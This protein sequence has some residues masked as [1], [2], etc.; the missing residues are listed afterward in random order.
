REGFPADPLLIADLDRLELRFLERQAAR[1]DMDPRLPEGVRRARSASHEQ[2]L[3][4]MLERPAGDAEALFELA[5]LRAAFLGTCHVESAEMAA[6]SIWQRVAA[7]ELNAELRGIAQERFAAIVAEEVDLTLQQKIHLLRETGAVMGA[8][9]A[10]SDE[11]LFRRLATRLEHAAGDRSLYQRMESLLSRGGV[12]ALET[13][14]LFLLVVVFV[15]LGIEA[16]V[17]GLSESTLRWMRIADATICT[18]FVLEFLFKFTL[19]PR[20]ASWFVRNFLTDLLPAI[21]AVALFFDAEVVG[22]GIMSLRLVRFLRLA[23]FARYM[24]ALR[25]LLAL[26]RLLLF[27]LRG[28]DAMIERFAPLLNRSFVLFEEG[29]HRGAEVDEQSPRLV[30]FRAI[31]REHVLLDEQPASATCEVL[32]G[33]AAALAARFAATPLA[34]N[35][36][37]Q[38][39]IARDVPVEEAIERLYS[40]RPEE[41]S[42]TMRRADLLALDRVVRVINA[43]VIRSMPLIRWLRSD[44]RSDTPEQR[45]VDLGRRIADQMERWR[46]RL[47][48]FAD[49]HGIVTGPQ[50]LDRVA[51]AMVKAS[52]RPA[53]RLLMF[54]GLFSIVRM[55]TAQGSFLNETLKKFVATPLVV[56]GSVCLVILLV[57]RWLKRIAGEAAESLKRTSEAHF[58]NLLELEKARTKDQDLVFLARRVFRFEMDDWEAALALAQQVHS[59]SAGSLHPLEVKAVAE[60]PVAI[61][62]DLSRVAYLYLHFLDGAILHESDIKTSEQLLANLS[63][64]NIRRNHL[65]FSRRDRK[66]VRRLSLASGSLLSG[67]YLWFRCITESVSLEAAKRVTDYNRHC[68]TLQ[69][70]AVSEPAEVADMDSW[71]AMRGQRVDGRILERL[72]APDVG[73]AFRTTEFNAMDFLSDNPQRMAQL[74]RVFG[75][76]VVGLL[77]RDRQRMIREIFGTKPL[78]RLPRSR[79]SI[80]VYRFFRARLSRGRILLAPLAMLGAFG[81]V[82]RSVLQRLVGIV[83][84]ILWPERAGNRGRLGTAPFRVALRK[85]HRM[86]A[87]GLL[88]AMQMR[89]H[90]D[91]VYCGAPPTWSF[92]DRMDDVA[93][94]E[95]DM[96]FLQ[97]RER[98][99]AVMRSLAAD[100][101]R[102]VEQL[103]G[104]LRGFTLGAEQSDDIARRLAERSV[105]IA[106]VTNRDGL[107]SLFQAEEWFERELPRLEDPQLRIEGSMVRAVVGALRRGFAPHPARRLIRGTLQARRVSRRGLRNLLRAYDGDQGRVRDMV[108][109]WVALPDGVTPTQRARELALRFY[110]AHGE[111]SRELVALRAVQ[112]LSVLDVRNYR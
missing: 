80:N 26:V 98:E 45:V 66:R 61:L 93:E 92:G 12:V 27:L 62:E 50:V 103:H 41:L 108:D 21:P 94:L 3:R 24:A 58:I 110:R 106:Y 63:L 35:P 14:S 2:S 64:E 107:R 96:D 99:R 79:R 87:P 71:L 78:H 90:F 20:K 81:W 36:D 40:I 91:P 67:P 23:A 13:T 44:E 89:V 104:L 111:V 33:R 48:F 6:Q 1:R 49:L 82:V 85:I 18:F 8:L 83:R 68:L 109:A 46:N 52:Q 51:T 105:T 15:L 32:L 4:G 22:T 37:A 43:P 73:D 77:R 55:F 53:V 72:D 102:R 97:L 74:E 75:G 31:R 54:G 59:A 5:E 76:E 25:P 9:A 60:P 38:V 19:A 112:S 28:L 17:P 30:L 100:N 29:T 88:E 84:E 16:S 34:D 39:R 57:G 7:V 47:L 101:R 56:L 11:R 65:T 95:C 42:M 70:R 10:R 69:Q 86:K